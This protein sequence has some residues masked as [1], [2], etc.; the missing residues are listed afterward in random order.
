VCLIA[1]ILLALGLAKAYTVRFRQDV[2]QLVAWSEDPAVTQDK[3][4]K[5][6][7]LHRWSDHHLY[8]LTEIMKDLIGQNLVAG[9]EAVVTLTPGQFHLY[10]GGSSSVMYIGVGRGQEGLPGRI[11]QH[12]FLLRPRPRRHPRCPALRAVRLG[13]DLQDRDRYTARSRITAGL[14]EPKSE[15]LTPPRPEHATPGCHGGC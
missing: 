6:L 2:N 4:H 8:Q 13:G 7:A 10:P 14:L 9:P 1:L 5:N 12:Q 11:K 15:E 3:V